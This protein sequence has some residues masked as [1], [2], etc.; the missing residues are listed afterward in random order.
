M[1]KHVLITGASGFLGA[2]IAN[3]LVQLGFHVIA[4]VRPNSD[5]WRI[6]EIKSKMYFVQLNTL[7][8][9]QKIIALQPQILIHCAWIGVEAADRNSISVQLK[10]IEF[11]QELM[12]LAKHLSLEKIIAL[13]SQAE[14]GQIEGVVNEKNVCHPETAYG[15]VKLQVHAMLQ[16]FCEKQKID[17][18]WLRI[19]SVFG[20][21]ENHSWFIPSL[22]NN[23]LVDNTM[24]MTEGKQVYAYLYIEDFKKIISAL[25]TKKIMPGIY[26]VSSPNEMSIKE[27]AET[28]KSLINPSFKINYGA[29]PYRK[30]QSMRVRGEISKLRSQ[31]AEIPFTDINFALL[32]TIEYFANKKAN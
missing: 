2:H 10:N 31:I 21:L 24:D 1:P 17:L 25:V 4:L 9:H 7:S 14:Y 5:L 11:A 29:I 3:E 18:I 16:E 28:L 20:P 27:M 30:G 8:W 12:F 19:F 26:N 23:M 15:Q 6:Q 13:G 22:I 32:K